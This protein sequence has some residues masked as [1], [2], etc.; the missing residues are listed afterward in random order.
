MR[1]FTGIQPTGTL[2]LGNYLGSIKNFKKTVNPED[3]S[4]FCIVDL[5]ALTVNPDAKTLHENIKS[6][7]ALYIALDLHKI[8]N[9]FVQSSVRAHSELAWMLQCHTRN[10]ELER[11][12]QYKDKSQK[13]INVSTGLF[14]YPVLMASDILLYDADIVPVGVDQKQH[15]ELTRDLAERVNGFYKKD[16]FTIPEPKIEGPS[17]K[18]YSLT[19]PTKK[20]SKSDENLKSFISMLDDEKTITKKIKSAT[21][22]SIG[23]INFDPENQPGVSN[24]LTIFSTCRGI[25]MDETLTHFDAQGYGFLK[26]EVA[27]AVCD[28]LLPIQ[29]K[30]FEIMNDEQMIIDALASGTEKANL[31]AEQKIIDVKKTFGLFNV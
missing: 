23:E 28:E 18:I 11:M 10:G 4:F 12:T 5:H 15:I 29:E 9:I 31:V 17:A 30:Y 25:S 26:T 24:L 8:T 22:D 6:L 3:E 7:C 21:T 27:K 16:L 20:M 1:I 13:K 2:T 19:D 14:T